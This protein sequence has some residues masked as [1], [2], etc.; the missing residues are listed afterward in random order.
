MGEALLSRALVDGVL[1]EVACIDGLVEG[2]VASLAVGAAV[3]VARWRGKASLL[4]E[5][6]GS[7][8]RRGAVVLRAVV[9]HPLAVI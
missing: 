8:G 7:R 4:G 9:V 3:V 1:N 2:I 5:D 6:C